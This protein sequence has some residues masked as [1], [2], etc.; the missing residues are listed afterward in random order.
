MNIFKSPLFLQNNHFTKK[1]FFNFSEIDSLFLNDTKPLNDP[2]QLLEGN[3]QYTFFDIFKNKKPSG[4]G[5]TD[6]VMDDVYY[7]YLYGN[8]YQQQPS[9]EKRLL[10]DKTKQLT[11]LIESF[12]I[13]S[14]ASQH[15]P[16]LFELSKNMIDNIIN[17][18]VDLG[19]ESHFAGTHLYLK[20][21][22]SQNKNMLL[23]DYLIEKNFLR[24]DSFVDMDI[25]FTFH[26]KDN[27]DRNFDDLSIH[28]SNPLYIAAYFRDLN[29]LDKLMTQA[30]N[31][32][33]FDTII[34]QASFDNETGRF[35]RFLIDDKK[36]ISHIQK[37]FRFLNKEY[38]MYSHQFL[39][40]KTSLDTVDL[41][42]AQ[43]C[44]DKSALLNMD[45]LAIMAFGSSAENYISQTPLTEEKNKQLQSLF[46]R[47]GYDFTPEKQEILLSHYL[48]YHKEVNTFSS[49]DFSVNENAPLIKLITINKFNMNTF[50]HSY[51][52]PIS[53]R[54]NLFIDKIDD[55]CTFLS[56]IDNQQFQKI[57]TDMFDNINYKRL[58][59]EMENYSHD[60]EMNSDYF[61]DNIDK[62]FSEII[63]LKEKLP[64]L[65]AINSDFFMDKIHAIQKNL[66]HIEPYKSSKTEQVSLSQRNLLE[67]HIHVERKVLQIKTEIPLENSKLK[68]N[69]I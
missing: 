23:A 21:L 12:E 69:R 31:D 22:T 53:A 39:N 38:A 43:G 32:L 16:A 2:F 35:T 27:S 17:L 54:K 4:N 55:I 5:R 51:D 28:L 11:T 19:F 36:S 3:L 9:D 8:D 57:M 62:L 42:T 34:S 68:I 52:S 60:K 14:H 24:Y 50:R 13:L 56:G 49:W 59:K 26:G 46:S 18:T 67:F 44:L 15:N 1:P 33:G 64:E 65:W 25:S 58:I 66:S 10:V 48:S 63:L 30:K 6:G 47:H 29:T 40:K 20:N 45:L 61:S 37:N 7:R 41:F